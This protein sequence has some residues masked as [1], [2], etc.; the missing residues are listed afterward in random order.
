MYVYV[1]IYVSVCAGVKNCH[2]CFC[3]V[4]IVKRATRIVLLDIALH[5]SDGTLK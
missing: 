2:C 5:E 4:A 1:N 3:G